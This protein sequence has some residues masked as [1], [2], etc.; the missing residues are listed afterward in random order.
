MAGDYIPQKR[1]DYK[2]WLENLRDALPTEGPSFN[3]PPADVTEVVDKVTEQLALMAA[4]AAAESALNAA[5]AAERAG[6]AETD[7]LVRKKGGDWK[8]LTTFTEAHAQRLRLK[9]SSTEFNPDTHK[10][11]F[12]VRIVAGEIRLDWK[13]GGSQGVHVYSRLRGQANWTLIGM[14]TSSPYIDG[15]PLAQPGV[16]E[17]REYMLRGVVKDAE[18]G[19]DSDILSVMWSGQ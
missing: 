1:N 17:V 13:K 5:R 8:R 16:P 11:E 7:A 15:R 18:I 6:E 14:D 10:P 9:G 12:A 4:T 3:A 2:E 19:Q